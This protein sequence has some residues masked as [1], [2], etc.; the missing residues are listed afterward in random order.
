MGVT[1]IKTH[2]AVADQILSK[3]AD[4]EDCGKL[5]LPP[6]FEAVDPDALETLVEH[7]TSFKLSFTYYGYEVAFENPGGIDVTETGE[8]QLPEERI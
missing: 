8:T 3:V 5:D 1:Q 7:D 4:A 2:E 6:L